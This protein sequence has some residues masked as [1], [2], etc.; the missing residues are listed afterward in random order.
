M[1]SHQVNVGHALTANN[2]EMAGITTLTNNLDFSRN[3]IKI[4]RETASGISSADGS[5]FIGDYAATGMG[6][7]TSNRRNIVTVL[8]HYNMVVLVLMLMN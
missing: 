7:S 6:Q 4:G 3:L 1:L 8:V 2:V 5:I